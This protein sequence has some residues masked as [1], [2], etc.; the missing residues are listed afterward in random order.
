MTGLDS[1]LMSTKEVKTYEEIKRVMA[2]QIRQIETAKNLG[3]SE[4]QVRRLVKR[5]TEGGKEGL[6]HRLRGKVSHKKIKAEKKDQIID[7]YAERYRDFSLTL[8][9]EKFLEIER[10]SINQERLRKDRKRAE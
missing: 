2:G 8:A 4:R 3:I 1:N 5:V 9:Q 7:L 6:I 10:K